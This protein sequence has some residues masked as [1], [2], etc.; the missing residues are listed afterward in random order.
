VLKVAKINNRG[1]CNPN[2]MIEYIQEERKYSD[3]LCPK[4][5]LSSRHGFKKYFITHQF[6]QMDIGITNA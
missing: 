5:A 2:E 4:F 1:H 6:F 3:L